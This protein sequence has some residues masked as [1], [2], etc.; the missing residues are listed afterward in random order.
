[1][2]T[3]FLRREAVQHEVHE[4]ENPCFEIVPML[5]SL[6]VFTDPRTNLQYCDK[7]SEYANSSHQDQTVKSVRLVTGVM[8]S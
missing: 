3:A 1:M 4:R 8:D 5:F 2:R 6:R 7:T